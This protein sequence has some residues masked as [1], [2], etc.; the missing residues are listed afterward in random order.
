MKSWVC[1]RSLKTVCTSKL[2]KSANPSRFSTFSKEIL[3][4]SSCN[5]FKCPSM[6]ANSKFAVLNKNLHWSMNLEKFFN[7]INSKF[8]WVTESWNSVNC[9]IDR[10]SIKFSVDLK[11]LSL[12]LCNSTACNKWTHSIFI[13]SF[14]ISSTFLIWVATR[15]P[16]ALP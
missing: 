16:K 4:N 9:L 6:E 14:N 15:N 1:N 12:T 3:L 13:V 2:I 11:S 5:V 8:N 10:C 7:L